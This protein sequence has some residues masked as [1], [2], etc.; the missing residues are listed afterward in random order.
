LCAL[1]KAPVSYGD[2]WRTTPTDINAAEC[3]AVIAAVERFADVIHDKT[4]LFALD[5]TSALHAA[6]RSGRAA[7]LETVASALRKRLDA[8][9]IRRSFRYIGTKENPADEPSRGVLPCAAKIA[10]A[11]TFVSAKC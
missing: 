1:G 8:L 3:A 7:A 9:N 10:A 2:T 6:T 4:V 11:A 5:N